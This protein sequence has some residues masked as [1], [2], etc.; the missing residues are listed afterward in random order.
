[1]K[2]VAEAVRQELSL[3]LAAAVKDPAAARAVVTGVDMSADLRGARVR[4]RVLD[5]VS[6]RDGEAAPAREAVLQ[7][8]GR[9]AGM[10]RREVGHRLGL[11]YAPELRFV[12]DDGLEE[13]ARVE[14]LL[15]EIEAERTARPPGDG[16]T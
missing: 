11:R 14:R 16:E 4:V 7:A 9:A 3:L 10:L 5:H 6:E 1:V 15:A 13:S 8:L 2:R 12:F